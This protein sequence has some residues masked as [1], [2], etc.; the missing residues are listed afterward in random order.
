MSEA[1]H[2]KEILPEAMATIRNR[3]ERQS[4]HRDRVFSAVRGFMDGGRKQ[5][6]KGN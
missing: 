4:H 6:R 3:M 1:Q 2:I 5:R